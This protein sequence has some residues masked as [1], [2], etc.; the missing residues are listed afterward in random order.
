MASK[1]WRQPETPRRAARSTP[2]SWLPLSSELAQETSVIG[3]D[4]ALAQLNSDLALVSGTGS[5]TVVVEGEAGIGKTT[6]LA[7]FARSVHAQSVNR[8]AATVLYG[9]C[10]PDP[11]PLEPFRSLFEYVV[12]HLPADVLEA[13]TAHSGPRLGRMLPRRSDDLDPDGMTDIDDA[14]E[15][16][17][18]FDAAG[19]LLRRI[20][21]TNPV[22][23]LLDDLQWAEPTALG[24]L[25][26]LGRQLVDAPIL[27]VLSVRDTD[28]H[29][30]SQLSAAL[31]DLERR[32]S[33]RIALPGLSDADLAELAASLVP[34]DDGAIDDTVTTRLREA[35]AGN[36][37]Y[38]IHLV[39]HWADSGHLAPR[40]GSEA[41]EPDADERAAEGV[42]A[43]LRNLLWSRVTMLG[44][45]VVEV[46]SA[47]AVLG[48]EFTE[49]AVIAMVD[50]PERAAMNAL[51]VAERARLLVNLGPSAETM[52]FVHALVAGAVYSELPG[53]RRRRLHAAAAR[54]LELRSD[55]LAPQL[56]VQLAAPLRGRRPARRS[57]ALGQDRG[58]RG[59][60]FVV[61]GRSGPLVPDRARPRSGPR[62]RRLRAGRSPRPPRARPAPGQ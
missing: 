62:D 6:L 39:R 45:D 19:D 37:L 35:T 7:G 40:D 29:R 53:R 15:R 36:P 14:T 41:I 13:H 46:L 32:P 43:S 23:V 33:R 38:A 56:T 42:P 44:D 34:V 47:A 51:D 21:A 22:V 48:T 27:W 10:P 12:E 28:Q 4:R 24:L 20:G 54:A 9:R 59:H 55:H 26:H 3:R 50:I 52:R 18:L 25:R 11:A 2:S 58:R 30:G 60:R 61:T 1:R 8:G 16:H 17:L 57:V 49:D 31:A 5:R